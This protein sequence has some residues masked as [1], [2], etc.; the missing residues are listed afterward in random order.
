M[1]NWMLNNNNSELMRKALMTDIERALLNPASVFD[2]PEELLEA[3]DLSRD[4]KIEILR[5]WEYDARQLQVAEEENMVGPRV[6]MLDRILSALR[7]L[8]AEPELEKAAPTK[9]G[10][11]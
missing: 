10:G 9:H 5:H 8:D 7:W 6:N 2:T 11:K 1:E 4:Q 3:E